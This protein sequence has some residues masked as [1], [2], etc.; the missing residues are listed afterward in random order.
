MTELKPCPFCGNAEP[1]I[2][3]SGYDKYVLCPN[4]LNEMWNDFDLTDEQ[5]I[6]SWNRRA[7]E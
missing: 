7:R 1:Y 2:C 5:L 6:K 3:H 4:C